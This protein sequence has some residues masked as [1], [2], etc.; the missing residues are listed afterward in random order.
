MEDSDLLK[1]ILHQIALDTKLDP[2]AQQF[3]SQS[4]NMDELARVILNQGSRS[5]FLDI[6]E[7]DD[8]IYASIGRC[9]NKKSIG[10]DKILVAR[11][12]RR[13]G[14]YI[15]DGRKDANPAIDSNPIPAQIQ[16]EAELTYDKTSEDIKEEELR[17]EKHYY[18]KVKQWAN[19]NGYDNCIVTGGKTPG[20]KWEN[21][22]LIAVDFETNRLSRSLIYEVTS[23]EVKLKVE[24]YAC[25]QAAHYLGF[26]NRSYVVFTKE[27]NQ[28]RSESEG[29]VFDLAI[30]LGLG[31]LSYDKESGEFKE[32]QSPRTHYPSATMI[33][34]IIINFQNEF[35]ALIKAAS[36]S[37]SRL[38]TVSIT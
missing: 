3:L 9:L 36:N 27:E 28:V 2:K 19:K 13:G 5:E 6:K 7:M 32:I 35:D 1:Q 14:I 37:F 15:Y 17:L 26:S 21:P 29:R 38:F 20:Y 4:H 24:P 10:N 34:G 8:Y 16:I 33:E 30:Q 22:D 23:F 25:W 18:G 11:L 12:G 31:V